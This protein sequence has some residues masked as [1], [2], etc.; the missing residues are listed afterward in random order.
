MTNIGGNNDQS[1]IV[2]DKRLTLLSLFEEESLD[3]ILWQVANATDLAVAL[4]DYKGDECTDCINYAE[5][6]RFARERGASL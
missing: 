3:D 4:A 5:F 1:G 2:S 6:C